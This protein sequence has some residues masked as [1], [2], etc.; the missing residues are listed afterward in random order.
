[1]PLKLIIEAT[2]SEVNVYCDSVFSGQISA[3]CEFPVHE[4]LGFKSAGNQCPG[5]QNR[6]TNG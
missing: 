1:M 5:Q 6:L 3:M 4:I 2:K